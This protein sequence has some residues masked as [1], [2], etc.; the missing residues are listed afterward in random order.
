MG[1]KAK[2]KQQRRQQQGNPSRESGGETP[3]YKDTDFVEE[4]EQQGYPSL[5]GDRAPEIPP[6]RSK[7]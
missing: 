2:L 7:S 5:G 4:F 1:R 3:R 6:P